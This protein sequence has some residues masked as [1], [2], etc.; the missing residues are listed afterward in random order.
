MR[1]EHLVSLLMEQVENL[2][3][4]LEVVKN[5]QDSLVNNNRENLDASVKSEEFLFVKIDH[6]QKSIKAELRR[7]DMD[8]DLRLKE[9]RLSELIKYYSTIDTKAARNMV[10][11][12]QHIANY[13]KEISRLNYQ[14]GFLIDHAKEI[15][16]QVIRA[17]AQNKNA[18]LDRRV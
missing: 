14:N 15:V 10:L 16:K 3:E 4:L 1:H 9:I 13:M 17:V 6:M 11:I 5:Q 18:I 8:E 12:R 2:K 7:I